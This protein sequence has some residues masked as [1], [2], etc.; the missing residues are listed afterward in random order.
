[1][2]VSGREH[3]DREIRADGVRKGD[4]LH[5]TFMGGDGYVTVDYKRSA[6]GFTTLKWNSWGGP[7][8]DRIPNNKM[9][10]VKK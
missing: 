7:V 2:G 1:V 8:K 5:L 9:V 3:Y 6:H 4:Q 10:W